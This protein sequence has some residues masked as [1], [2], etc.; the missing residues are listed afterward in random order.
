MR[1][2]FF[3]LKR[4]DELTAIRASVTG[5]SFVREFRL[6]PSERIISFHSRVSYPGFQLADALVREASLE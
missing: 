5:C 2:N 4:V 3:K 1:H 6:S